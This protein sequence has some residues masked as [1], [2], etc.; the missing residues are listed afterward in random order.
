MSIT[1]ERAQEIET[2]VDNILTQNEL[3]PRFDLTHFLFQKGFQIVQQE[4]DDDTTGMLFVDDN[5]FIP[6]T[7]SN[8]LIVINS[9]LKQ[10]DDFIQR[11]RYISAHEFAHEQLHKKE[12]VQYAHRDY[13][14][15]ETQEE[16][17]ADYF[18]RC[19]LMP[20]KFI[21]SLFSLEQFKQLPFN[22]KVAIV[23][24]VFNVTESKAQ[25]RLESDL[26]YHA[27]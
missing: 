5:N 13:S 27:G 17:E 8:K 3:S 18:A 1:K 16:M 7:Q 14:K 19:L 4:L 23:S 11:R 26:G 12:Q 9:K 25:K 15:K 10:K 21:E 24:S 22:M 2:L 20:R 6:G